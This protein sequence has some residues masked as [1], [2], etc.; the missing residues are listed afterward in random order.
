M[1]PDYSAEPGSYHVARVPYMKEPMDAV[2]DPEVRQVTWMFAA[3]TTKSQGL[4]NIIGYYIDQNP[5]PM[6]M[7]RPTV[8]DAQDFS[9]ER[10][11]PMLEDTPAL[12]G[13][14][15]EAKSRDGSNTILHKRYP[16]GYIVLVGANAP[17]GLRGWQARVVVCDEVDGFP[18]SAGTEGDPIQLVSVRATTYP[19][20]KVVLVSTP[21]VKGASRIESAYE[22]SSREQWCVQCSCGEWQPYEWDRVRFGENNVEPLMACRGCGELQGEWWWK[23]REA[24]WIAR[25]Q[26]YTHRGFHLNGLASPFLSWPQLVGE[27]RA[28]N[29]AG[30]EEL[31]VFINTRLAELWEPEGERLD[32]DL[33]S[34]RR[35]R[36][37]CDVPN[38]VVWLTCGIDVQKDR[39]EYE[40]VGWGE[41]NES[42]GIV[43]GVIEGDIAKPGTYEKIDKLIGREFTREDGARLS[44]SVT[45]IDSQY[46]TDAVH[47]YCA[48]RNVRRVFAIRGEGRVGHPIVSRMRKTG[49]NRDRYYFPV[50]VNAAKDLFASML[51]TDVGQPGCCHFPVELTLG[52]GSPR[53]YDEKYIRGLLSE[54]RVLHRRAGRN[55]HVWEKKKQG[56]RNEPLDTRVY[57]IAGLKIIPPDYE[58]LRQALRGEKKKTVVARAPKKE[59]GWKIIGKG[60]LR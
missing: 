50:G 13:K 25:E 10:L 44:I 12:R 26:N 51:A 4:L 29:E 19:D 59:A 57:A 23:S 1:L 39:L 28:A 43:Y 34:R 17:R 37:D 36:Y 31:Q 21:T 58:M 16:G 56:I 8:E 45:C 35:E 33:F 2:C 15:S 7:V 46:Q 47:E 60:A 5:S 38:D 18:V 48:P 53:G 24:K 27:F 11:A 20:S 54:K 40:I 6:L 49:K 14:I 22:R 41:G 9:K 55:Y 42:W 3:Q 52:D 30:R 32:E